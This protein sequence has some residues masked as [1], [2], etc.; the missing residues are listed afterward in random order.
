VQSRK[1][2]AAVKVPW[3]LGLIATR[4]LDRPVPGINELV[5]RARERIRSGLQAHAALQALRADQANAD[6]R[7]QFEA[8]RADLGYGLLLLRYTR[9]PAAATSEQIERAAW[10]TVPNV[11]VLFWCFASWWRW[12][13]F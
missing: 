12:D 9:D 10:S 2:Y 4:S 6:A 5:A 7:A 8:H 13:S 11:P 1:T 3:L